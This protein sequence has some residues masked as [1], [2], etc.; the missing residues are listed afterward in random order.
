MLLPSWR[1]RGI[2]VCV[3]VTVN[4][5]PSRYDLADDSSCIDTSV[6]TPVMALEALSNCSLQLDL[7]RLCEGI[8]QLHVERQELLVTELLTAAEFELLLEG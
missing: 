8:F 4:A 5:N 2:S 6:V 3:P 1:R 7:R